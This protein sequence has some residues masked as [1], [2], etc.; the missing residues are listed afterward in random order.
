[1]LKSAYNII[2]SFAQ[3]ILYIYIYINILPVSGTFVLLV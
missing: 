2:Y 3:F 1:M